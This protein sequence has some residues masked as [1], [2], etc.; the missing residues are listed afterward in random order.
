MSRLA[1]TFGTLLSKRVLV[2]RRNRSEVKLV[3]TLSYP[4]WSSLF[5][6]PENSLDE[7]GRQTVWQDGEFRP[8]RPSIL[9]LQAPCRL[10][11]AWLLFLLHSVLVCGVPVASYHL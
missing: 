7:Q 8:L 2:S 5:N 3:L 4:T 9:V 10:T 11:V 6:I 1:G